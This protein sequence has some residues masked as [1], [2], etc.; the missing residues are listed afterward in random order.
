[1]LSQVK[2]LTHLSHCK[3]NEYFDNKKG[4]KDLFSSEVYKIC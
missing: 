4:N 3:D 1:M 2:E